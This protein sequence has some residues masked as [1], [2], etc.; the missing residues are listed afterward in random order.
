MKH[1]MILISTG[2]I[3]LLF[4]VLKISLLKINMKSHL[5][6]L[7]KKVMEV[8]TLLQLKKDLLKQLKQTQLVI[9][10]LE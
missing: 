4:Q 2:I 8:L 3:L 10:E 1:H 7:I 6:I 9:L 5:Y